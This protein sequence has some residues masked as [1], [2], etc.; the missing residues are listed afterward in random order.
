MKY[1][2]ILGGLMGFLVVFTVAIVVGKPPLAALT[3]ASLG[4]IANGLLFMWVGQIWQKNVK[5]MLMAKRQA[6]MAAMAEAEE[7][8]QQEAKA[9]G[10]KPV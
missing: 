6:A 10:S 4:S 9:K 8:K 1:M 3:Q 5:Q 2:M 7:R